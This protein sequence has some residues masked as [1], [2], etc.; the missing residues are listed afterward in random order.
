MNLYA[1]LLGI[2]SSLSIWRIS[3]EVPVREAMHWSTSALVVLLGALIGARIGFILW[4][5]AYLEAFGWQVLHIWEGGF[6][7]PGAVAGAWFAILLISWQ[8]HLP[9]G[10]VADRIAVMAPPVNHNGLVGL[11][12]SRVRIWTIIAG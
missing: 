11:L 7:W 4:Q 6:I 5:P 12:D 2:G 8:L 3:R 10:L 9:V 1:L